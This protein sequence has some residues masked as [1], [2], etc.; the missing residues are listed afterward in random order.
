MK[1]AEEQH[2]GE[3]L[4][5][6]GRERE[7]RRSKTSNTEHIESEI[8]HKTEKPDQNDRTNSLL[9]QK[10]ADGQNPLKQEN[11]SREIADEKTR[12]RHPFPRTER[13]PTIKHHD[14]VETKGEEEGENGTN[15]D[16][17]GS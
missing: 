13:A 4:I 5:Q 1:D 6:A 10:V 2:H 11:E 3:R 17:E 14:D 9:D 8:G 12:G 15:G 16:E 7:P